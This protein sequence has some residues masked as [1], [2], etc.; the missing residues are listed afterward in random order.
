[1]KRKNG[2]SVPEYVKLY[3]EN[4]KEGTMDTKEKGF[5]GLISEYRKEIMGFAALWIL[6]FHKWLLLF[7]NVP[8]IGQIEFLSKN[9]GYIGTDIFF[10]LSG[11]GLCRAIE[12]HSVLSFYA[13]RFS[14]ILIPY[15]IAEGL[16]VLLFKRTFLDFIKL[17]TGYSFIAESIFTTQWF[18]PAIAIFYLLFPLYYRLFVKAQNKALFT[19]ILLEIWLF[20]TIKFSD[21]V[22]GDLLMLT[23]RI[24][25]LLLGVLFGWIGTNKDIIINRS[26]VILMTATL[27]LGLYFCYLTNQKDFY[28]LVPFSNVAFPALMVSFSLCFLIPYCLDLIKKKKV[29]GKVLSFFGMMSLEVYLVSEPAGDYLIPIFYGKMPDIVLNLLLFAI[30]TAIA[31]LL[32]QVC[33]LIP[34]MLI[35]ES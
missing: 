7:E 31:F 4:K 1:M 10:F 33:K 8:V 19:L 5:C 14:R 24:P 28:M 2:L 30:V 34:K 3:K 26:L 27:L 6:F 20:L 17:S 16:I 29:L 22:R 11:M 23:N 9:F 21:Y 25:I 13:R 35:R 12:K 15:I 32:Y 18:V